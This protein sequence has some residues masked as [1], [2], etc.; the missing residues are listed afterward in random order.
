MKTCVASLLNKAFSVFYLIG[1]L[2]W[3]KEQ[4]SAVVRTSCHKKSGLLQSTD[5]FRRLSANKILDS[6]GKQQDEQKI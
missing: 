2:S 5:W 4:K 1:S 3:K 6:P